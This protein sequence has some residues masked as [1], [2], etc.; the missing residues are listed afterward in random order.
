MDQDK[1]FKDDREQITVKTME[2]FNLPP[3]TKGYIDN[4]LNGKIDESLLIC[5][6]SDCSVCQQTVYDCLQEIKK[7][8][9]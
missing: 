5:C 9:G 6:H 8:L 4:L 3:V 2:L 7:Q 1:L